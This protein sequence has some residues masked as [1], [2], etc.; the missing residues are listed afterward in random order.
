MFA[1]ATFNG[2]V[3]LQMHNHAEVRD[4]LMVRLMGYLK[5]HSGMEYFSRE[6]GSSQSEP[7]K[8]PRVGSVSRAY[9]TC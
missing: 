2:I 6:V 8:D 4:Q 5:E 9:T 7:H 1:I 3:A